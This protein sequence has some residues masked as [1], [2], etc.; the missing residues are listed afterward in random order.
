MTK[1]NYPPKPFRENRRDVLIDM[2]QELRLGLIVTSPGL[3]AVHVPVL[4]KQDG[5][6]LYLESHVG[7][8]N[9]IW[10]E[11][12]GHEALV[13]FQGPHAY[14]HPGWYATK[15]QTGKAVPTW[16]YISVQARGRIEVVQDDDWLRSHVDQL[17][18]I[19]ESAQAEPWAIGDAPDDYMADMLGG[20]VGLRIEVTTLEGIWKM[21]QNHPKGNRVGAINGLS[22][23]DG[24]E[25]AEIMRDLEADRG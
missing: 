9:P 10:K 7:V 15:K 1:P 17:S 19:M 5:D 24:I 23:G 25:V 18:Q 4:V 11:S 21:S 12:D 3:D 8:A 20:I 2:I 13:V 6:K 14:V 22:A 16:N